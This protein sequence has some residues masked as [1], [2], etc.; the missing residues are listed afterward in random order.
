MSQVCPQGAG[1]WKSGIARLVAA[2]SDP[3]KN[4]GRHPGQHSSQ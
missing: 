4:C 3:A 2:F 1:T